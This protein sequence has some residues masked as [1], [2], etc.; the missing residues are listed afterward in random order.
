MTQFNKQ[1]VQGQL[2]IIEQQSSSVGCAG[3]EPVPQRSMQHVSQQ[4]TQT[5]HPRDSNAHPAIPAPVDTTI[6]V[7]PC[8]A[9]SILSF[10][11]N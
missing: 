3:G 11:D 4:A 10:S 5:A 6:I 9:I 1:S 7:Q 2:H 8:A